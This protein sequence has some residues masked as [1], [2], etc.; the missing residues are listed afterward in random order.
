MTPAQIITFRSLY[1]QFS[2][3]IDATLQIYFE[4][5]NLILKPKCKDLSEMITFAMMAHLIESYSDPARNISSSTIDKVSVSFGT[6]TGNQSD[7]KL[8]LS[9]TPY[10]QQVL[11]LINMCNAGTGKYIG[12]S[13]DR[14]SI[15]RV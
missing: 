4:Q 3:V 14:Y 5:A 6:G 8:W 13:L 7:W 9:G 1:P 15:R 11:A 12:H 10:G 2:T